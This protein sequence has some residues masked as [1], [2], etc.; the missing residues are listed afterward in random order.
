MT[1]GVG[2]QLDHRSQT[3][4]VTTRPAYRDPDFPREAGP[5]R[6]RHRRS[7]MLSREPQLPST[8][9]AA[10]S[11]TSAVSS[12][13]AVLAQSRSN[14]RRAPINSE[15][16][17]AGQVAPNFNGGVARRHPSGIRG[18]ALRE[19]SPPPRSRARATRSSRRTSSR[20]AVLVEEI[21]H[22]PGRLDNDATAPSGLSPLAATSR[23]GF[24]HPLATAPGAVP[25]SPWAAPGR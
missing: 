7:V 20:P 25:R 8:T 17:G 4:G 16:D 23:P 6:G 13:T 22:A 10:A 1:D 3:S 2:R 14:W 19:R 9:R 18:S 24:P 21:G 11:K 12:T 5:A 15:P